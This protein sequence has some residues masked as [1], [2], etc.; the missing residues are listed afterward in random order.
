MIFPFSKKNHYNLQKELINSSEFVHGIS[1]RMTGGTGSANCLGSIEAKSMGEGW[2]DAIAMFILRRPDD[3]RQTDFTMGSYVINA[4]GGI[5]SF[6]YS[7][8]MDTNPLTCNP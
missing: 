8:N 7:T 6:P 1:N 5:R 3:T 2:S 4:A